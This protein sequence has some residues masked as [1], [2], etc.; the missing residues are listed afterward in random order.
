VR[1]ALDFLEQ[2]HIGAAVN[3]QAGG[4]GGQC[5]A[6]SLL[7]GL[8]D[9]LV[10][11]AAAQVA[12]ERI[13]DFATAQTLTPA[14][15]HLH[16]MCQAHHDAGRAK[17]ALAAVA[18]DHG[19]LHGVQRAIGFFEALDGFDRFAV[20]AGQQLNAGIHRQVVHPC[21]RRVQLAHQHHACTA[22]ALGTAL[23]GACALQFLTQIVQNGGGA[24]LALGFDDAAVEHE[25]H[26]VGDLGHGA[27]KW[28]DWGRD[29][30]FI[31]PTI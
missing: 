18:L 15:H 7:R 6:A 8:D 19:I 30:N 28:S 5:G 12:A 2:R 25:A 23:F 16:H 3:F 9:G 11:R 10:A 24:A 20:Q 22:I 27:A 4:V 26:G 21:A 13:A 14:G 31:G 29:P 17:A 1:V